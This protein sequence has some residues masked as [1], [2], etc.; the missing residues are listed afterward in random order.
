MTEDAAFVKAAHRLW[1]EESIRQTE[2][3]ARQLLNQN[4]KAAA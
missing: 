2:E 1:T 3:L 4:Q